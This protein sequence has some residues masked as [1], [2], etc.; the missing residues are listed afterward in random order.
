M[1][2]INTEGDLLSTNLW[3]D[4][5][6]SFYNE[7][8]VVILNSGYNIIDVRGDLLSPNQWFHWCGKFN[9]GSARVRLNGK[10]YYIN[11]EGK[12]YDEDKNFIRNLRESIKER[13]IDTII[14][15][16]LRKYLKK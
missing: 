1:N 2:F 7:Y 3:F 5:A 15:S 16:T 8:A 14:E 11:G 9:N 10:Y 6:Y 13:K 4:D 12:L